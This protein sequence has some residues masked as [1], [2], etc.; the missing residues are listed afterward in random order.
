VSSNRR[1]DAQ[2]A[3]NS[4][5]PIANPVKPCTIFGR[6]LLLLLL[7]LFFHFLLNNFPSTLCEMRPISPASFLLMI[8]RTQVPLPG[9][10]GQTFHP[11]G[12]GQTFHPGGVGQTFHPG[13][14]GQTFHRSIRKY[15]CLIQTSSS[16]KSKLFPDSLQTFSRLS[17]QSSVF[18]RDYNEHHRAS[19][20]K[21]NNFDGRRSFISSSFLFKT[22]YETLQLTSDA[23]PKEIKNAFYRLSKKYHPDLN[24]GDRKAEEMFKAVSA[25]YNVLGDASAKAQYDRD[26]ASSSSSSW[27]SSRTSQS[28]GTRKESSSYESADWRYMDNERFKR[29]QEE[30]WRRIKEHEEKFG[31]G[32]FRRQASDSGFGN[33]KRTGRFDRWT[34]PKGAEQTFKDQ[35]YQEYADYRDRQYGYDSRKRNKSPLRNMSIWQVLAISFFV[36]LFFSVAF[37]SDLHSPY[38]GRGPPR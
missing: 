13:G 21:G 4:P 29:E 16:L 17:P 8:G 14:V 10:V 31:G 24:P 30:V 12:V 5:L 18:S 9:G 22:H 32:D 28:H 36:S 11:R 38:Q 20:F 15:S 26:L 2:Q 35:Q 23:K 19:S 33:F 34:P 27:S 37:P 7:L 6:I 1:T 25:A 3:N